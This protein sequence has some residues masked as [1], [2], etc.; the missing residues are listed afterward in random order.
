MGSALGTIICIFGTKGG[1]G[2]TTVAANLAVALGHQ[3]QKTALIDF[4][5]QAGAV[6]QVLGVAADKTIDDLIQSADFAHAADYL[7]P[8][9]QDLS[10]LV[11]PQRPELTL[12][13]GSSAAAQTLSAL[14]D[15]FSFV[16]VDLPATL[17]DHVSGALEAADFIGLV[18]GNDIL[19]IK[20]AVFALQNLALLGYDLQT[21]RVIVN[22]FDRHGLTE[23]EVEAAV[24][25]PIFWRI[26][27]DKSLLDSLNRSKPV[28][29]DNPKSPVSVTI[30]RLAL[31]LAI[32][33]GKARGRR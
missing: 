31:A 4:D 24:G 13:L 10:V 30:K 1:V 28:V 5:L 17:A 29:L 33:Y 25:L 32:E 2:R 27:R 6:D 7:T 18:T 23:E 21:V 11:S 20:N 14:R 22:A 9:D 3:G 8:F 16:V 15:V 19:S 12:T 26:D